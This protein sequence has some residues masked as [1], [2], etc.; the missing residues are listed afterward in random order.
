MASPYH[1]GQVALL[2]AL[3][4]AEAEAE[5]TSVI[6]I[7]RALKI[8]VEE[9]QFPELGVV[10]QDTLEPD[11]NGIQLCEDDDCVDP[12]AI[13]HAL[14]QASFAGRLHCVRALHSLQAKKHSGSFL[15]GR[16]RAYAF[17][18][19]VEGNHVEV[20]R[21][22]SK[23]IGSAS[24]ALLGYAVATKYR[25][26]HY[27]Y[28]TESME[29]VSIEWRKRMQTMEMMLPRAAPS[30]LPSGTQLFALHVSRRQSGMMQY[31][32]AA[33]PCYC[34]ECYCFVYIFQGSGPQ[35]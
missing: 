32:F 7:R 35:A 27:P 21:D 29:G 5:K 2:D 9:C 6:D 33:I 34:E 4:K 20:V 15:T 10:W 22:L 3:E 24:F 11:H 18:K 30:F 1:R 8:A 13:G 16:F 14:V 31:L 25:E 23:P 26:G 17:L 28:V 19:A 12:Q